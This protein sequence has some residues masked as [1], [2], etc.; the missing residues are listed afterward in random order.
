[1]QTK[2]WN[3][4]AFGL[5]FT[6]LLC[7]TQVGGAQ[8]TSDRFVPFAEFV[9]S[10]RTVASTQYVGAAQARVSSTSAFDEMRQHLLRMYDSIHV[11][12]SYVLDSQYFDCVPINEQPSVRLL[13]LRNVE[14]A[15]P[16]LPQLS[17]GAAGRGPDASKPATQ[18]APDQKVDR[19]GNSIPC[20]RGTIPLRRITLEEMTRFMNLRDFFRK[21]GRAVATHKY[22]HAYQNVGNHGGGQFINLWNPKVDTSQTEIFSLAQ[23]WFVNF[24]ADGKVQ[25]VEGGWQDY[26]G[27]YSLTKPV[28]FIYWTADGYNATGCYNTDCPGFVQ[29]NPSVHLGASFTNF[30]PPGG[31]QYEIELHWF[32]SGGK[33][34]FYYGGGDAAHAVGYYPASLYSSGPLATQGSEVDYG[35][36][37]VGTTSWPPM[38]SGKPPKR[39]FGYAAYQRLIHYYTTGD[40]FANTTLIPNQPSPSCYKIKLFNNSSDPN[41]RTYFYFG[42]PGGTG[43]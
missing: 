20:E 38:G 40:L 3:R 19:F 18:I 13:G 14:T 30:S 6:I 27:K 34:W 36:E 25:T 1:M 24:R 37:T 17:G 16:S 23:H 39:G 26:P 4:V 11:G 10:V 35:G 22:A 15:P 28:L 32:L 2:M 29:T 5:G 7:S 8:T 12:H 42:G 21:E 31:T 33:W 9:Q 43:C 41:Y